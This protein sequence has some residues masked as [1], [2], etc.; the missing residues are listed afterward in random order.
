MSFPTSNYSHFNISSTTAPGTEASSLSI[1]N[2]AF[3]LLL[4]AVVI[5]VVVVNLMVLISMKY[6]TK[7]LATDV[8]IFSLSLA[9]VLVGTFSLQF[10]A[11]TR[12]FMDKPWSK[13]ACDI[14]VVSLNTLRFAAG[15][16]IAL[17]ALERTYL[18][19]CPLW[20]HVKVT[21]P[22]AKIAVAILW[23]VSFLLGL[24]PV[25]GVG[26][27]SFNN[28]QCLYQFYFLGISTSV[29]LLTTAFL[30]MISAF[31][32]LVI[33][34][35]TGN[36]F[37]QRQKSMIEKNAGQLNIDVPDSM[38]DNKTRTMSLEQKRASTASLKKAKG[39]KEVKQLTKMMTA[40]II[41]YY[42]SF[43]PVLVC[44]FM[45]LF[46]HVCVLSYASFKPFYFS[47]RHKNPLDYH[48]FLKETFHPGYIA[49]RCCCLQTK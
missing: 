21:I 23:I 40:V 49:S 16:T 18:I 29:I 36:R 43:L 25:I 14:F 34:K 7:I 44:E 13:V 35:V 38:I 24:L 15:F 12:Y 47:M 1:S 41:I 37:I 46:S 31:V 26:H 4:E 20:Y 5:T 48:S 32:C 39:V 33:I 8:F 11:I 27:S 42:I 10:L 22:K 45:S 28:G 19:V 17:I 3:G 30:L 9:D 2:T 6:H